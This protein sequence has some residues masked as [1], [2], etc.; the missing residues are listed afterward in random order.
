VSEEREGQVGVLELLEAHQRDEIVHHAVNAA[1]AEGPELG[2]SGRRLSMAPVIVSEHDEPFGYEPFGDAELALRMLSEA[3]RDVDDASKGPSGRTFRTKRALPSLA[4]C[5]NSVII[6]RSCTSCRR[7]ATF[8]VFH[9]LPVAM[10]LDLAL[11]YP[12]ATSIS[13]GIRPNTRNSPRAQR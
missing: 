13:L 2:R 1:R 7:D 6:T 9:A 8:A 12:P 10:I 5:Q 4:W 11:G 3:V